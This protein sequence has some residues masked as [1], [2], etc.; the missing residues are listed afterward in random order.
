MPIVDRRR[1]LAACGATAAAAVAGCLDGV[2]D[3]SDGESAD[4]GTVP[5]GARWLPAPTAFDR[6]AYAAFSVDVAAFYDLRESLPSALTDELSGLT[7]FP[8]I[9]RQ[10]QIDSV[11]LVGNR[12][13]VVTGE[14]DRD[15]V[16]DHYEEGG[17]ERLGTREGFTLLEG[18]LGVVRPSRVF[19]VRDGAMVAATPA[20]SDDDRPLRPVAEAV[21]DADAGAGD[22]Y[23]EV[24]DSFRRLLESLPAG[25]TF[26]GAAIPSGETTGGIRANGTAS[27]VGS[28][29]TDLE[30]VVRF[31][32]DELEEDRSLADV[33]NSSEFFRGA[34]VETTTD[35]GTFRALATVSTDQLESLPVGL[36]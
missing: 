12:A 33:A 34:D 8:G 19:A 13:S 18:T 35:G 30:A 11:H 5:D 25:E 6:N 1:L 36:L 2:P 28:T 16:I 31:E 20:S 29:T 9:D 10:A 3:S 24:N 15:A 4:A 17:F 21:V 26:G 32:A 23:H 14:F 7:S 27:A 22:R